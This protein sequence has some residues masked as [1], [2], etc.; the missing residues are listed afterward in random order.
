MKH[1]K[2]RPWKV[3]NNGMDSSGR[4]V[5]RIEHRREELE[6]NARLIA[7]A[8]ELLEA[9][10]ALVETIKEILP[11]E[12]YSSYTEQAKQAIKKAEGENE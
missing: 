6:A 12:G 9:C 5:Y 1:T 2:G 3:Y 11:I 4:G 8:P 10:K 7:S